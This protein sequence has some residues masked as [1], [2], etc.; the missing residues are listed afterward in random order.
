M[1]VLPKHSRVKKDML[2]AYHAAGNK[3]DKQN[4]FEDYWKLMKYLNQIDM[5]ELKDFNA[6]FC[7]TLDDDDKNN[8]G[9]Y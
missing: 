8:E 4:E 6:D 2:K 5:G 7:S 1:Y 9:A 3:K